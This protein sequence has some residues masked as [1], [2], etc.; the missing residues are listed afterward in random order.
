MNEDRAVSIMET[1]APLGVS[2]YKKIVFLTGA[3]LSKASGLPTYRG[4]GGIWSSKQV[5]L[6]GTK[7]AIEADPVRVW[8]SYLDMHRAI[9]NVKPNA[10]HLAIAELQREV[11]EECWVCV[12]TQNVDGLHQLAGSETVIEVHGSLR[13]LRCTQCDIKP[14]TTPDQLEDDPPPCP[15]CGAHSRFDVVLFNEP[16]DSMLGLKALALLGDCDLY[17]V[18][19]TS[20]LVAPAS[21]FIELAEEA[22]ARTV[23]VNTEPQDGRFDENYLG[24]AEEVLPVLLG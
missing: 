10:A 18:V 15:Q 17:I 11:S 5:E 9:V 19:G 4:E 20:G 14:W 24:R 21:Q 8:R 23:C 3:G 16:V 2:A 12:L 6:V 7:E 13:R 1:A 22:G